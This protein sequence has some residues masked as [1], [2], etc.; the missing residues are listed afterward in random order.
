MVPP[1]SWVTRRI[2]GWKH[3]EGS[4]RTLAD[5]PGGEIAEGPASVSQGCRTKASHPG[6]HSIRNVL[7]LGSGDLTKVS[8]EL[9]LPGGREGGSAPGLSPWLVDGP[10]VL[11]VQVSPFN[12]DVSH[13][14]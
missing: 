5:A 11:S 4:Q 2:E 10:S 9:V 12:K 1:P 13:I 8:S 6:R 7:S 14:R 3:I